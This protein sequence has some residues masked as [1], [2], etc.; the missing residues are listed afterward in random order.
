MYRDY[1][2][3][4]EQ[5]FSL[6]PNPEFLFLSSHH[7]EAFAHL[8]YG[9]DTRAGFIELSGEVG[10][11]KTTVIRTLLNQLD[12]ET[13]RT[14]LVFNPSISP[15]GL[16]QE[17]NREFGL[18]CSST[19]T[20]DL[21][22]ALNGFLLEENSTGH[23]VVL[24][25]DEAQ[26]LAP[27]VLEQI[28]LI[29]NLETERA[30]LIQLVLVGQPEL[31]HLLARQELRQLDQRITVRY[32]LEPMGFSDTRDYIRHR[33]RIAA[34]GREPV[35]FSVGAVKRVFSF[36]KGL[37]RL[38]NAACDRAL[39][40]AYT[41]E[42]R[43]ISP[44]MASRSI[45]DLRKEEHAPFAI[46]RY[47]VAV[48]IVAILA[49]GAALWRHTG[50]V[51]NHTPDSAAKAV[52][53]RDAALASLSARPEQEGDL[54][55]LNAVFREWQ[56]PSVAFAAGKPVD[57][58][59]LA[60][61]RGFVLTEV[62]GKLDVLARFDLPALLWI[63]LPRGGGRLVALTGL[64]KGRVAVTPAV[65]GRSLLSEAELGS[66]WSGK[67]LVLWKNFHDISTRL[68]PGSGDGNVDKL[69]GLLK[70]T[71]FFAGDVYGSFDSRTVDAIRA[72]QRSEGI[73]ADGRLGEKTLLLLYRRGGGFFPPGLSHAGVNGE[74][75]TNNEPGG[76]S[77]AEHNG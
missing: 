32:H 13:H 75:R 49:L 52:L 23:A 24:V 14:A 1:F 35:V 18:P 17:I 55:A 7:Q 46:R 41:T 53:T 65:A 5:P 33:I 54:A 8:L 25:I 71:G 6:T 67:A 21:L 48:L 68:K 30:K 15:L 58:R 9:I 59:A 16:L 57:L 44:V 34:G 63:E 61:E 70:A 10:T 45:S 76:V 42:A 47:A 39:L 56:S 73:T 26:N 29:S 69:Q 43:E 27:E 19:E 3:F 51:P 50:A 22:E 11:G 72:F 64:D 4:S 20:R 28:R 36:S 77:G 74:A 31:K 66:I 60:R 2:G 12:P 38:I 62:T 40:L 37:P